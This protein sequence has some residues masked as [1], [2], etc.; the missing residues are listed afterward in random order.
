MRFF[1]GPKDG[2]LVPFEHLEEGVPPVLKIYTA[3]S[4]EGGWVD[5]YRPDTFGR[6]QYAGREDL[7]S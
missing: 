7:E 4:D 3:T 2:E 5:T 6:M 1:G